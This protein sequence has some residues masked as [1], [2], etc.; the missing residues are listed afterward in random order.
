MASPILVAVVSLLAVLLMMLGESRISRRNERELR[1][2]GAIEP[3]D[4]VYSTMRW[5]YPAAFVAMAAEGAVFGPF[6]AGVTLAGALLLV[7]AKALKWWAM[8]SLGTRWAFRVLIVPD[9]P[10]V[11]R[12]PYAVLR[13][14]NYVAVVGELVSMALMVG[15]TVSAPITL[16]LFSLLLRRRIRVENRALRYPP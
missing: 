14:P 3:P 6:A 12:G 4:D 1:R 11:T 16:L 2:R 8:A 10:L 9:A 7:A 15:A 5:A 13:H